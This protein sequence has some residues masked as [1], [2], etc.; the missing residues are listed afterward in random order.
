ME[1]IKESLARWSQR[2][3][4]RQ[5]LQ[6][7]YTSIALGLVL[8]AGVLGLVNQQLGQQVLAAAIASAAVFLI[9]SVAWALLQSFVL[10]KVATTRP[11][12]TTPQQ[13]PKAT[14]KK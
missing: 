10:L 11:V 5:K 1:T 13:K 6:H 12:K 2:T 9:N 3:T 14:R 4:D 8:A 7:M